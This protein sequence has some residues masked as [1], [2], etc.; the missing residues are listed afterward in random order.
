MLLIQGQ[1]TNSWSRCITYDIIFAHAKSACTLLLY[2]IK[3]HHH[4]HY[5]WRGKFLKNANLIKNFHLHNSPKF[6]HVS[7]SDNLLRSLVKENYK[8]WRLNSAKNGYH[9]LFYE[10]KGKKRR[11]KRK[12]NGENGIGIINQRWPLPLCSPHRFPIILYRVAKQCFFL[13][14]P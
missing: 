2:L 14:F 3:N 7:P 12:K 13:S 10:Q 1:L 4:H 8:L 11:R 9:V 5:R 6:A